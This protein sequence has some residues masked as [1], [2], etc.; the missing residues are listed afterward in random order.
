MIVRDGALKGRKGPRF[1]GRE[2]MLNSF[3]FDTLDYDGRRA[4]NAILS[5]LQNGERECTI[6]ARDR[7]SAERVWKAVVFD[8]PDIINY[9]IIFALI[10]QAIGYY[11]VMYMSAMVG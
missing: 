3:Y 2:V 5:A 1:S 6:E 10:W 8:N 4:Y 11:M 9:S 7:Q